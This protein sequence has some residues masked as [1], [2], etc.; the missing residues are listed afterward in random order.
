MT[1]AAELARRIG[2]IRST[3]LPA[4]AVAWAKVGIL[5]TVGVTLAGAGE[6]LRPYCRPGVAAHSARA[7]AAV[8]HATAASPRS[9]PR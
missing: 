1:I 2:A 8:R 7:G 6:R 3:D 5:D 4:E 9:M